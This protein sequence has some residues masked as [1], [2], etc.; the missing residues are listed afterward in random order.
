[1]YACHF[2]CLALSPANAIF[3]GN[4]C[5][6]NWDGKFFGIIGRSEIKTLSLLPISVITVPFMTFGPR[7]VICNRVPLR[8]LGTSRLRINNTGTPT[9]NLSLSKGTPD[10]SKE[11]KNS[12]GYDVTWY[13]P[14][15]YLQIHIL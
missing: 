9:F 3:K 1:M 7:C 12:I 8:S 6:L 11:L 13:S 5:L 2:E 14:L 15:P 10:N 4:C